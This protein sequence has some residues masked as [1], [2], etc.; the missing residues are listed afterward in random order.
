MANV[1][2][3]EYLLGIGSYVFLMSA[4]GC[5]LFGL[6]GGFSGVELMKF[7]GLL[8]LGVLSS[9]LLGSAIGM[10]VKNQMSASSVVIP[11][12]MVSAFLPMISMFN[13]TCE[14][15][16]RYLYTQQINY[17]VNDMSVKNMTGDRF[18]IIFMNMILFFAIFFICY[19]KKNLAD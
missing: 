15:F 10:L 18:F 3:L 5:L 14:K 17:L 9:M 7:I 2:P 12:A 6:V 11:V 16:A 4:L 19:K 13:A 1:K 8:L